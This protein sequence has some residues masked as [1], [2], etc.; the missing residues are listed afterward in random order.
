MMVYQNDPDNESLHIY[1]L[2]TKDD[3]ELNNEVS[4]TPVIHGDYI[5]YVVPAGDNMYNFKRIDLY[6]GKVESAKGTTESDIHIIENGNIVFSA[7]GN[8]VFSVSEWDKI[9]EGG[10]TGMVAYVYYSN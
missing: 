2:K 10:F 3:Y 4:Y 1:D 6:T 5:Y 7:P 9:G 8:P